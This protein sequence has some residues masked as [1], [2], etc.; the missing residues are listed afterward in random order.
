M[1]EPQAVLPVFHFPA[2]K[3]LTFPG[4]QEATPQ[5][6]V[7]L[8]ATDPMVDSADDCVERAGTVVSGGLVY[9][10]GYQTALEIVT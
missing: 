7:R 9:C 3:V 8:L 4:H 6:W 5:A 2:H 1:Q 10:Q